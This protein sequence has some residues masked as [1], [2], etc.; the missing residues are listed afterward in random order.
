MTKNSKHEPE[1]FLNT[2]QRDVS[3]SISISSYP[4]KTSN[5]AQVEVKW[6]EWS[7]PS[8]HCPECV[9]Y[10]AIPETD[11]GICH[12]YPKEEVVESEYWCGEFVRKSPRM[13]TK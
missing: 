13:E 9:Y 12:R 11:A 5:P 3:K 4:V 2:S 1:E 10:E 6:T 8:R 7:Q